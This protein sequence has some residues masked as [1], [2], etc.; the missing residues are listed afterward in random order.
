VGRTLARRRRMGAAG[1]TI[2][3]AE[4]LVVCFDLGHDDDE[5]HLS[6]EE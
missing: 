2:A 6:F 5:E 4:Q 3:E 1:T